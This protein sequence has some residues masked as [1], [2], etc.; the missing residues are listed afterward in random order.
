MDELLFR[1][2]DIADEE[3]L[4]YFVETEKDR[5][6]IDQLKSKTPIILVGSRGV[7]KSFLMKVAQIELSRDFKTSKVLP[8]YLTFRKSSLITCDEEF[9]FFHWML[10]RICV[11][12][13]KQ[14]RHKGLLADVPKSINVISGGEYDDNKK[15]QIEYILEQYEQSWKQK[16]EI[17]SSCVPSIEDFQNAIEDICKELGIKRINLLIDEA[18]HI[19]IPQ[20]QRQFFTLFRDLRCPYITCNAA[21]YPG[22][23]S[24]G[25]VFQPM[26][27]ATMISINR[28]IS[29]PNYVNDMRQIVEKQVGAD[30][31]LI[32]EINSQGEYFAIMA[33]AASGNPR[34][35]LKTIGA[36]EKF[37]STQVNQVIKSFY[38]DKLLSEHTELRN[39][40]PTL[41]K[42][43]DWGR[44]YIETIVLPELQSKNANYLTKD[45]IETSCYIWIHKN[46]PAFVRNAINLLEYTG[47]VQEHTKALKSSGSEIGNRYLINLGCLFAIEALP[48]SVGFKIAK[49][50]KINKMT[51]YGMNNITFEPLKEEVYK[52]ENHDMS[53]DLARQLSKPIDVLDLTLWTITNLKKINILTI[54]DL[55]TT[56]ENDIKKI[57]YVGDKRARHIKSTATTAIYEYLIG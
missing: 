10:S 22:V 45:P 28:D 44:S 12:I 35:M 31:N 37:K 51:E 15:S 16:K 6:I 25:D 57:Y 53:E 8:V 47:I 27:D 3:I 4:D 9:K 30:S 52:F 55:L 43:I 23:T 18:A 1:T 29:S 41:E 46:A 34:F 24:Y 54:E 21:V 5:V 26:Q 42:L 20:Q 40:Y 36:T 19:F 14:L 33:Y 13:I 2:E 7:G 11:E 48:H 32:S 56:K 49:N 50:L 38:K 39:K 17:D